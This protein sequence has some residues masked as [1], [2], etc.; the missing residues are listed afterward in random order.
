[1]KRFATVVAALT[2]LLVIA[3]GTVTSTRSGD[4]VP[5]W[6]FPIVQFGIEMEHRH[7]AGLVGILTMILAGV[8]AFR[9]ERPWIRRLGLAAG[10][11]V[12]I[13]ALLGGFR[14]FAGPRPEIA[15][16]HATLAQVFFCIVVLIPVFLRWKAR[17]QLDPAGAVMVGALLIQ[18]VLG[19]VVRHTEIFVIPHGVGAIAVIVMAL[20]LRRRPA[21]LVLLFAQVF[22]GGASLLIRWADLIAAR[23]YIATAHVGVGALV[24]AVAVVSSFRPAQPELRLEVAAA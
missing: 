17:P 24:L 14:I 22:L 12:I 11:L 20:W 1:M 7:L 16:A 13:Q 3:G 4:D 18:L 8:L 19:A 5:T 6:P 15:V 9:E 10:I 23:P 2:F 21:L